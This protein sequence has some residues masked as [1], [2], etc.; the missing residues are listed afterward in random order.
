[1]GYHHNFYE[2][3]I[4]LTA[5]LLFAGGDGANSMKVFNKWRACHAL[6]ARKKKLDP[7]LHLVISRTAWTE[8]YYKYSVVMTSTGIQ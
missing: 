7:S 5:C 8:S 6:K 3:V 4:M 2:A 1:M